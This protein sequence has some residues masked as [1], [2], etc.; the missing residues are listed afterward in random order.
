MTFSL[1]EAAR[2]FVGSLLLL[3][4]VPSLCAAD[5]LTVSPTHLF[6]SAPA[7][8]TTLTVRAKG[9]RPAFLQIRVM[10]WR[11]GTDPRAISPT[12]DVVASPPFA[13]L[14]P[15]QELTVRV[16]RVARQPLHAPKCY[17][18]LVDLLPG[19]EQNGHAVRLLIRQ[20]IP[21]CFTN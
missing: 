11:K 9:R 15:R 16:V 3:V 1:L 14:L 12:Q 21:L 18:V 5:S 19:P 8:Q 4:A 13:R 6:I 10:R 7:T 2:V 17:R 20:S